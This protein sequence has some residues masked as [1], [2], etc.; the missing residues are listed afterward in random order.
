M[1]KVQLTLTNEESSILSSYGG[2]FG[3]S[4]PKTIRYIISKAAESYLR[5]DTLPAYPMSKKTEQA[6]LRAKQQYQSGKTAQ[7]KNVDEFIDSL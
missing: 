7:L 6:G 5:E 3:Y 1:N 4:L 2:R